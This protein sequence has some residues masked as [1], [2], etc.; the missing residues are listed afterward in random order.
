MVLVGGPFQTGTRVPGA[1]EA[2]PLKGISAAYGL[3]GA[4]LVG[5]ALG[6]GIDAYLHSAPW[7][8]ILGTLF[9]FASGLYGVYKATLKP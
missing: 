2:E 9:G 6:Y 7:G 4:M 1:I 5:A 8:M 3:L